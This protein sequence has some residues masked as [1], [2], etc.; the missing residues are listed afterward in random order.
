LFEMQDAA[1]DDYLVDL[2]LLLFVCGG[3]LIRF[4]YDSLR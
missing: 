4:F 3:S 2:L 1:L